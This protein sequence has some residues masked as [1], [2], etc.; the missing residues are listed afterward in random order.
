MTVECEDIC[1]PEPFCCILGVTSSQPI[2]GPGDGTTEPDWEL[3]DDESL[4]ALLR[5]ER[6]RGGT[7][8]I[9][10]IIVECMDA[11]GNT[12][13]AIVE[14]TVPHDQGKGKGKK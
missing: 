5:A 1:D 6:P 8:R 11:S 3:F 10:T 9:Y 4:V 13:T 14:V 7:G 12:A 2:N